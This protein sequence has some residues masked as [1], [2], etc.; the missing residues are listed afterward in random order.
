MRADYSSQI[1]CHVYAS[2]MLCCEKVR[3]HFARFSFGSQ[4]RNEPLSVLAVT[5]RMNLSV[6]AVT[7]R[8]N[9]CQFWQSRSE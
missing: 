2:V 4:G 9:L 6:L 8:M 5:V 7:V 1:R 3:T